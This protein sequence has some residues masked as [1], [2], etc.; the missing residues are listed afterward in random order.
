MGA[1]GDA[2]LSE[3]QSQEMAIKL[4][5]EEGDGEAKK[6]RKCVLYRANSMC[7]DTEMRGGVFMELK[8]FQ[9]D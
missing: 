1:H 9:Y 6:E 2:I 7:K 8:E 4:M 3:G 5:T